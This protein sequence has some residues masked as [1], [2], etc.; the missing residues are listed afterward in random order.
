[1]SEEW[2]REEAEA[3]RALG[4]DVP[5][6]A[7]AEERLVQALRGE[8]LLARAV[9][10][11]WR[12]WGRAALAATA[13]LAAFTAGLLVGARD[14]PAPREDSRPQFLL[15]VY[16]DASYAHASPEA[17]AARVHEYRA[18]ARGLA[19]AGHLVGAA[20]LSATEYV[21]G[22]AGEDRGSGPV[23]S[24]YFTIAAAD[25][26]E[27]LRLARSCPHLRHGGRLALRPIETLPAEG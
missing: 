21:L 15:L 8:G 18:W 10:P 4:Q 22:G 12:R 9:P 19:A 17:R 27:A 23:V 24:G 11:P 16:Q 25:A 3:L 6:P 1:M 14:R 26:E 2:E 7:G 5:P 20:K 13:G